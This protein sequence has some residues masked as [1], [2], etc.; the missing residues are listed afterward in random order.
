[1]HEGLRFLDNMHTHTLRTGVQTHARSTKHAHVQTNVPLYLWVL[2][3]PRE[4]ALLRHVR[5]VIRTVQIHQIPEPK[6]IR[7]HANA[8]THSRMHKRTHTRRRRK[9]TTDQY[10]A[11]PGP[12]VQ[13]L[14]MCG[15]TLT[16]AFIIRAQTQPQSFGKS[17]STNNCQAVCACNVKCTPTLSHSLPEECE[18]RLPLQN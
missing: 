13:Y 7:R 11:F 3:N 10:D 9:K 15:M 1:M 14:R 17:Y 6:S 8:R 16:Q 2:A 12:R 5:V 18:K 4:P